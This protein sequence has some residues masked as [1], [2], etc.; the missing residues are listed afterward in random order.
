MQDSPNGFDT[1]MLGLSKAAWLRQLKD[2]VEK[3][4]HFQ[5]LGRQH[6]ATL[7][8]DKPVLLVT[9]ETIDGIQSRADTGQP[10][11]WELVRELGWSHLCI[12][13]NG[14]TWFR[15][16]A[17]FAYF[18]QL[19]AD[20]FFGRFDE[21][22]FYGTG[23]CGYAAAAFSAAAPE[24][25]VVAVQPQATLAPRLAG[26]DHRFPK[27][28]RLAFEGPYG[29]APQ[30]AATA[31]RCFVIYDPH[32]ALDA[33]HAT[34]FSIDNSTLLPTPF[35]GAAIENDLLEMQILYRVLVKAGAGTLSR[36]AFYKLY[37]ARQGHLPYL[38]RL[39]DAVS[40]K[41]RPFVSALLCA[42][43][44]RRLKAPRFLRHLNGLA[45]AAEQG[46]LAG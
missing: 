6:C 3:H 13:S 7:I 36:G 18:D 45:R 28:R 15:D 19:K 23:P 1:P 41:K 46:R 20:G 30:M 17:V 5:P 34:L 25:Q 9:F 14:D 42:N 11:G 29:F 4:G 2:V 26:W 33:M 10:L 12:L 39:L 40:G 27:A 31:D 22:V 8:E 24:A 16:P 37:R 38:N 44:A 21:V 35:L 43:V 32:E